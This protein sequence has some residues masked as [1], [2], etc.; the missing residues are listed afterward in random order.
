MKG[1]ECEMKKTARKWIARVLVFIMIATCVPMYQKQ[2]VKAADFS[3][4]GCVKWVKARA[5][6]IGITLPPTG[7]NSYGLAGASAFWTNLPAKFKR[8]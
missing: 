6:Q 8:K 4:G 5:A 2:E 3:N 1:V 7:Y